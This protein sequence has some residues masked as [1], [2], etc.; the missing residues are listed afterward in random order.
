MTA[1]RPRQDYGSRMDGVLASVQEIKKERKKER[2]RPS[3]KTLP[4]GG[5]A[6]PDFPTTL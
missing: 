6:R 1:F 4:G 5:N 2:K 3:E